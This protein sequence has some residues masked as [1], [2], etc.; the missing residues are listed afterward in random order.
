MEFL[1]SV[2]PEP[3]S[4]AENYT[5]KTSIG[6]VL[7][8]E[9]K[10]KKKRY[11]IW[12]V[13]DHAETNKEVG[14]QAVSVHD[15]RSGRR[16]RH[17]GVQGHLEGQRRFQTSSSCRPSRSWKSSATRACPGTSRR[18]RKPIRRSSSRSRPDD[19][20]RDPV[21]AQRAGGACPLRRLGELRNDLSLY[22]RV[23]AFS[24]GKHRFRCAC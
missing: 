1:K 9:K 19:R 14:A 3:S 22:R 24:F 15:R 17:H 23:M 20:G 11:I 8:G 18:S 16:R 13:C 12:N 21:R 10:G 5:G 2:L 6:V 7:K 4:L